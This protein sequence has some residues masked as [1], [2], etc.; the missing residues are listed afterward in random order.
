MTRNQI[1]SIFLAG[2]YCEYSPE[3]LHIPAKSFHPQG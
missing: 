1:H 2:V 3:P